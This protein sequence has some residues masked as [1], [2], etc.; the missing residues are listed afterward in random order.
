M[1]DLSPNF[2][3]WEGCIKTLKWLGLAVFNSK[4]R[5]GNC[6]GLNN[7][8]DLKIVGIINWE[9]S[10]TGLCQLFCSLPHWL[11]LDSPNY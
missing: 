5:S 4:R 3:E 2:R 10:Y 1:M 11:L 8:R 6:V 7:E 9:W